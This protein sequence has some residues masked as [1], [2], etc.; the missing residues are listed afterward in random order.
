MLNSVYFILFY[1]FVFGLFF[2]VHFYTQ[3]KEDKTTYVTNIHYGSQVTKTKFTR[4]KKLTKIT[5]LQGWDQLE[6]YK[7]KKYFKT[8]N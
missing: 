7:L 1:F 4:Y 3:H 5:D 6:K 8:D 2:M